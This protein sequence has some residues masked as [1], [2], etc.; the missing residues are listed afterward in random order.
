MTK[1]NDIVRMG[2]NRFLNT[3]EGRVSPL[4]EAWKSFLRW[5][6]DGIVAVGHARTLKRI[7]PFMIVMSGLNTIGEQKE[8]NVASRIAVTLF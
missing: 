8:L 3:A 4:C 1:K 5:G 2:A 6:K 7:V